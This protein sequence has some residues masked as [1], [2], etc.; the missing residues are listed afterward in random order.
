[1]ANIAF[2]EDVVFNIRAKSNMRDLI[3][4]AAKKLGKN[5]SEFMLDVAMREAQNVILDQAFFALESDA[6]DKVQA[7]LDAPPR[8]NDKLKSLFAKKSPWE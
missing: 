3:D 7:M 4:S 8:A 1:M 5:R 2:V 6:F